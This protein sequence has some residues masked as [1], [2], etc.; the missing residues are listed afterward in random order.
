MGLAMIDLPST[1]SRQVAADRGRLST[2]SCWLR[3]VGRGFLASHQHTE[4]HGVNERWI[5]SQCPHLLRRATRSCRLKRRNAET[6]G[7]TSEET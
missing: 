6:A 2:C 7:A 1:R 4:R 3:G 5:D